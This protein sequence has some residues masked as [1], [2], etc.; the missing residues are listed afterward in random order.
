MLEDHEWFLERV[1][2]EEMI[3][4]ILY[5]DPDRE[6]VS[7]IHS[8]DA[9]SGS[10]RAEEDTRTVFRTCIGVLSMLTGAVTCICLCLW[11]H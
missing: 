6:M 10:G 3:S 8:V 7:S 11:K 1:S 2:E 4:A 9:N 5:L